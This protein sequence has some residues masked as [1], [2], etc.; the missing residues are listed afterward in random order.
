MS[1]L[2]EFVRPSW[3]KAQTILNQEGVII[4]PNFPHPA[5]KSLSEPKLYTVVNHTCQ[6][7]R[8]K[9]A[10]ICHHIIAAAANEGKLIRVVA[11]YKPPSMDNLAAP[12]SG[13]SGG[14]KPGK[15]RK[16]VPLSERQVFDRSQ[17]TSLTHTG[18]G[19]E[20]DE[21]NIFE[22]VFIDTTLAYKCH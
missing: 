19:S 22:L 11:A 3:E 4:H 16:R 6:C 10:N 17:F 7:E 13:T 15:R 14:K 2:P 20:E 5:V 18:D 8:Y 21:E 12:K 1:G 9:A